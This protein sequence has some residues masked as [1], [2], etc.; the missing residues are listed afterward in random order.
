MMLSIQKTVQ[1][2]A[3]PAL[4][5][6]AITN[7]KQI[8]NYYPVDNVEA[9]KQVGEAIIFTGEIGGVSFKDDGII[10]SFERPFEF[11]YR[12]WS[13]NHGTE[14]TAENEMTIRYSLVEHANGTKLTLEHSNLLTPER[15]S[16]MN[17]TWDFLLDSLKTYVESNN[18]DAPLEL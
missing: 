6:D 1:I 10:E 4:V 17:D 7:P 16:M 2:D 3:A 15:Q 11:S 18:T 5:F 8:I 9:G 14:R 12:Y 13:D